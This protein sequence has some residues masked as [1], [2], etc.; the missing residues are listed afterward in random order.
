M[1]ISLE[2]CQFLVEIDEFLAENIILIELVIEFQLK[3]TNRTENW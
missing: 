3:L 2:N 1:E